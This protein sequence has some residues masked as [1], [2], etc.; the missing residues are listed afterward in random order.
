MMSFSLK[1]KLVES[2]RSWPGVTVGP[3]RFGGVEFSVEGKE[4]AHLHGD[5]HLDI[6]FSKT[7]RGEL[8][9]AGRAKPHH[10]YPHS[11]WVSVYLY[12]ET[13]LANATALLRMKY[14][15]LVSIKT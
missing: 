11:G 6:P 13:E 14:E 12:T 2:V 9:A 3:H 1:Q 5:H 4:I 8:V 10:I 7:V 15:Q